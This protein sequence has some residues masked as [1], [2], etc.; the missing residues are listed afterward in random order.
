MSRAF[1]GH[2]TRDPQS[3]SPRHA[4][5]R[6]ALRV[7]EA[8]ASCGVSTKTVQRWIKSE[9]LPIVRRRAA[10]AREITL[11]LPEDLDAWLRAARHDPA[12][13]TESNQSIHL[14]GRRFIGKKRPLDNRDDSRSSVHAK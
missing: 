10:G 9:G 3:E 2:D 12:A 11:I 7:S 6:L 8:A 13:V 5:P 4:V 1:D 14:Q